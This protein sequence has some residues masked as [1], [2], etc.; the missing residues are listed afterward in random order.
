M[1]Y[2]SSH[3]LF[4]RT[5]ATQKEQSRLT[6]SMSTTVCL[7]KEYTFEGYVWK[8]HILFKP[9]KSGKSGKLMPENLWE[10]CISVVYHWKGNF[11]FFQNLESDFF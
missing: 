5:K 6:C 2:E 7:E 9:Q 4:S 3:Y 1:F 11:Q 8:N 10:P